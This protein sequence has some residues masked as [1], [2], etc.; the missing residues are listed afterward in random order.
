[1]D[2]S[3]IINQGVP[4]GKKL[5]SLITKTP[6]EGFELAIALSRLGVKKT[7]KDIDVLKKIRTHH[8]ENASL[9]IEASKTIAMYFQIV[10]QANDYWKE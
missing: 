2:N 5:S 10:S 7:Q 8:S 4:Y 6:E 9:L 1:M 3:L